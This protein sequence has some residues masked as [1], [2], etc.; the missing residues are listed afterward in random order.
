MLAS[1]SI[2]LEMINGAY[3]DDGGGADEGERVRHERASLA[4]T[5]ARRFYGVDERL[6]SDA[7]HHPLARLV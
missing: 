6:H 5:V 2:A 7:K 3:D 1:Q 4:A